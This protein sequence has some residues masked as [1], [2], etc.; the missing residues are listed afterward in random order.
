MRVLIDA[1]MIG[2]RETG[3]ET[4]MANLLRGLAGINDKDEILI[5]AA[6]PEAVAPL[7][8]DARNFTLLPVSV[9]PF[10]RLLYDLPVL[11][12]RSE[13]DL[14]CVTYTGPLTTRCPMVVAV[15]DVSFKRHP[16]WFSRRDRLVLNFGVG[17]TLGRAAAVITLSEFSRR[18]I[19]AFYGQRAKHVLVVPSA[20][21]PHFTPSDQ[22]DAAVH[23][24]HGIRKPYVLAVGNL[25]P[26]KNLLR[27]IEAFARLATRDGFAH[28]LV[29]VGK[30]EWHASEIHAAVE[31]LRLS[32]RVRATGYVS[33]EDLPAI[34]RG[35]D[36]FIY[37]S[38]YE[39]FGLPVLEAM[40]CGTPVLTSDISSIVEVSGSAARLVDPLSVPDLANSIAE[41]CASSS[42]RAKWREQGLVQSRK[43]SCEHTARQ[44]LEVFHGTAHG[45]ATERPRTSRAPL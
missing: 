4:Y 5:A 20:P 10:R 28:D 27:L 13:P 41:M 38:L 30:A 39:G 6:H 23:V 35:A 17:L 1:H 16:E 12:S 18:E 14:V 24:R 33:A 21:A 32:E 29:L 40:A 7:I 43:F 25:Q 26:R 9:N 15:H 36:L 31:R 44:A 42:E 3:N 19:Q 45:F 2:E 8:G 37:P 11:A 34:Y 22:N